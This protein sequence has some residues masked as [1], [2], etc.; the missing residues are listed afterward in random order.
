MS[1][2]LHRTAALVG[3]ATVMLGLGVVPVIDAH[4]QMG[5]ET[6]KSSSSSDPADAA[7]AS[8]VQQALK[9]D[10]TLDSRHLKV[11]VQKGEVTLSGT[12][13]DN[14]VVLAAQQVATKSAPGHTIINNIRV[15]QGYQ[16]AP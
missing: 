14:R 4:A 12:A 1:T 13:Q 15:S 5:Q 10:P 16:N 9:N 8:R 2:R 11:F 3:A 6:P 7:L